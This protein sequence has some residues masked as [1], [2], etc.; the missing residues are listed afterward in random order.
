[1]MKRKLIIVFLYIFCGTLLIIHFTGCKKQ[2][3][4]KLTIAVEGREL[5]D[6][7]LFIDDKQ[8]GSLT[9][10]IIAA[11][12]MVYVN[13][14]FTARMH[15]QDNNQGLDIY[16]G[17]SDPI[18]LNAGKHTI[19][20]QKNKIQPLKVVVSVQPGYHLLTI[21]PEKALVKWGQKTIP[22]DSTNTVTISSEKNK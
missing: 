12:G 9:Q 17:C 18:H 14:K 3:S 21:L 11:D 15:N 22:I 13:G 16:A 20:L 1:M 5:S 10:T 19:I 2:E 4:A 7:H 8:V 6:A